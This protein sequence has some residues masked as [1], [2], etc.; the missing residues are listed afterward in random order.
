MLVNSVQFSAWVS[1]VEGHYTIH[2][3]FTVGD[4][5]SKN[6][7]PCSSDTYNGAIG[8]LGAIAEH[9]RVQYQ[10]QFPGLN[11]EIT[12]IEGREDWN[13]G[14]LAAALSWGIKL[15]KY[16]FRKSK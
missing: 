1:G 2:T 10:K 6:D 9:L 11:F 16:W 4:L 12:T 8:K 3:T 13:T 5:V 15:S 7:Y 14:D